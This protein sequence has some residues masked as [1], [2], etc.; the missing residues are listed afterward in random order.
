[1]LLTGFRSPRLCSVSPGAVERR[2]GLFVFVRRRLP[3]HQLDAARGRASGA[4]NV[5]AAVLDCLRAMRKPDESFD[6]EFAA[7]P[8]LLH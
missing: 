8:P 2:Y 1:M 5:E 3:R 7:E 4:R 6:Y